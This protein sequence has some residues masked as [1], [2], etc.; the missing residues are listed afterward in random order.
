MTRMLVHGPQ[1]APTRAI[2]LAAGF[3][4]RLAPLTRT[5][6]KAL[7]PLWGV[8]MLEHAIRLLGSW[9]VTD[10]LVNCHAQ[11]DR[12]IEALRGL[13]GSGSG[14]RLCLS[15]EPDILGT[16]GALGRASWFP[17]ERPFWLLNAD[18]AADLDPAPLLRY[19]PVGRRMAT[20]WM[21]PHQGPRT[22]Q[23]RRG[24]VTSFRS[25]RPGTPGTATLCGLHLLSPRI[26]SF[27]PPG[28]S[29]VVGAYEKAMAEGYTIRGVAVPGSYWADVGTPEQYLQAHADIQKRTCAGIPGARLKIPNRTVRP[30]GVTVQGFAAVDPTA[31]VA[32]GA[33]LTDSVV[34]AETR[35]EAGARLNRAVVSRGTYVDRAARRLVLP[36]ADALSPVELAVARTTEP[37][38]SEL[39]AECLPPRPGSGRT[40]TRIHGPS[41]TTMLVGYDPSRAE[42]TR[43]APLARFLRRQGLRVPKVLRDDP[44]HCLTL[45]EDVGG[46]SLED[47]ARTM[48]PAFVRRA[49][50]DILDQVRLVQG[51]ITRAALEQNVPLMEPFTRSIY[52]YEHGLFDDHVLKLTTDVPSAVRTAVLADLRR[53][54]NR[55]LREPK[56]LLHR[57]LQSSNLFRVGDHWVWIDFQ[58]M[59]LGPAAYDLASLICDPYV[60]LP[61]SLQLDLLAH[62]PAAS[63][64]GFWVAAVQRLTQALGAY[65]RLGNLPGNDHFSRYIAPAR[66]MLRRAVRLCELPLPGL[67]AW[68]ARTDG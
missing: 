56:V 65:G 31:R 21:E 18:V 39:T 37:A 22:V 5:L 43:Y 45:F 41:G 9:G 59:R 12:V 15:F 58:G 33:T 34:W 14:P 10:V 1:S 28:F 55:L 27:V 50:R 17:D 3:G 49:Y 29:T 8:P 7:V 24:I 63:V 64:A 46:D 66:A 20:V 53:I 67:E 60:S 25:L 16:G 47:L 23:L 48:D 57:D 36:A 42:N 54:S 6:P 51:P 30:R 35:I 26:L 62:Q 38:P 52:R 2:V 13:A 4:T 19:P 32:C 68:L 44:E 40:F 61:L 11:A